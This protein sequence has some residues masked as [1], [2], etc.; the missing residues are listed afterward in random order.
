MNL[1]S[2]SMGLFLKYNWLYNCV[3]FWCPAWFQVSIY[4]KMIPRRAASLGVNY[5]NELDGIGKLSAL[6]SRGNQGLKWGLPQP[7]TEP[8]GNP[9]GWQTLGG[10]RESA[11]GHRGQEWND[12]KKKPTLMYWNSSTGDSDRGEDSDMPVTPL[13]LLCFLVI[14]SSLFRMATTILSSLL[15][16]VLMAYKWQPRKRKKWCWTHKWWEPSALTIWWYLR[17]LEIKHKAM[18]WLRMFLP[19]GK[20]GTWKKN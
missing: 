14:R 11:S 18:K 6:V 2:F 17:T 15:W 20:V 1:V 12:L 10:R 19:W 8:Q 3:S 5:V 16:W 9:S 7:V 4:F 13:G